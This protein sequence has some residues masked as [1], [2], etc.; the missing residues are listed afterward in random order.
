ML[1]DIFFHIAGQVPVEQ[2]LSSAIKTGYIVDLDSGHPVYNGHFP[3]NPVVPG[4]CQIEMIR[5][6]LGVYMKHDVRFVK[7]DNVKYL[8]MINPLENNR[9]EIT[10]GI[11]GK[12]AGISDV[13]AIISA[14]PVV[15]LK[16][17]G[18]VKTEP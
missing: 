16:F 3:G 14:G 13:S 7:A 1:K 18:T 2:D 6:L 12:E 8:S 15:F 4:A 10:L 9:L 17:K 11:I 5:E